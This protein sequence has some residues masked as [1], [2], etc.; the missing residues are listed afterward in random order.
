MDAGPSMP[1]KRPAVAF[2]LRAAAIALFIPF[3]V[4][5]CAILAMR[6]RGGFTG[7]LEFASYLV[8]LVFGIPITAYGWWRFVCAWLWNWGSRFLLESAI[9][10]I[11]EKPPVIYLRSFRK[12][13]AITKEERAF[14]AILEDIG[15]VVAIGRPGEVAP[16]LGSARLYVSD[17]EWQA[18]IS[19]LIRRSCLVVMLA[20]KS[21]GLGWEIGECKRLLGPDRLLIFVPTDR[22]EY[23]GFAEL[24][25]RTFGVRLP[26][27]VRTERETGILSGILISFGLRR[28]PSFMDLA[29]L[30]GIISFKAGWQPVFIGLLDDR[31]SSGSWEGDLA[32]NLCEAL[33]QV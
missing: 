6:I 18:E 15:P 31:D 23:E 13:K 10:A 26:D 19:D 27:N 8:L 24:F 12:E 4:L 3:G 22:S 11:G 29:G 32:A 33:I 16:R 9:V 14:A 28:R 21:G 17:T 1:G 30:A 20:G 7:P 25:S 5:L 2:A